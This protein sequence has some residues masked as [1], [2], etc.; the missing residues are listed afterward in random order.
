MIGA[1]IIACALFVAPL[2]ERWVIRAASA[3]LMAAAV[4][5]IIAPLDT[6]LSG[7][8]FGFAFSFSHYT[9]TARF[10]GCGL[11]AFGG[12]A[13]LFV[14]SRQPARWLACGA[15]IHSG[16]SL[17]LLTVSD[18]LTF[19]VFWELITVGAVILIY[20]DQV[21]FSV[22]RRY[23]VYQ[24]AG[25]VAL[26]VG[27][28]VNYGATGGIALANIA[29]GHGYFLLAVSIKTAIIPLHLWLT[30]TYPSVSR[31]TVVVLSAYAT[32]AGVIGVGL[33]LPGAGLELLGAAVALI[34]VLYAL[35]QRGLREFLSF[36]IISQVGY[37]T[38][39]VGSGVP[40]AV[41]G[42][43]Y[44]L[45]SHIL[46]KGLLFMVAG[47]LI[48]CFGQS[49]MYRIDGEGK[50]KPLLMGAAI[51]GS[52]SIAGLPPFN[53]FISKSL[54]KHAL[55]G[56]A[57]SW[58]LIGASIG[59]ALSF[60]K[61][62]YLCFFRR[63]VA[64]RREESEP[65]PPTRP[66][67]PTPASQRSAMLL[68]ALGCVL[69]GTLPQVPLQRF[70][71]VRHA[72]YYPAGIWAGVWPVLAAVLLFVA[73]FAR[74]NA[75]LQRILPESPGLLRLTRRMLLATASQLRVA[76]NGHLLRYISWAIGGLVFVWATLLLR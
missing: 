69:L 10:V 71:A 25:A 57:A 40:L 1:V 24:M 13:L 66:V 18:L 38:A 54:L 41:S 46:Y 67:A 56:S 75:V 26:L 53:G 31:E 61:F 35:K 43:Y 8:F 72:F 44:H 36:H 60:T 45:V 64:A 14:L 5:H 58:L 34:A 21:G 65:Q 50:R 52:A 51:I 33:L 23:F 2:P 30:R 27:I 32:K 74:I 47:A 9:P 76:H 29:A 4:A 73:A 7:E 62:L 37:M 15:L 22:L 19:F 55:A 3:L 59:T 28:A 6:T 68:L 70:F 49:D 63:T 16:A 17:A 42:G 12:I 20:Q 39:G 48:D 11:A